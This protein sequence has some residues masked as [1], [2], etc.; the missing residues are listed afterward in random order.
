MKDGANQ[1]KLHYAVNAISPPARQ[2]AILQC[3]SPSVKRFEF[4]AS[5]IGKGHSISR[6]ANKC[7]GA[8]PLLWLL[9]YAGA[10]LQ[11][12]EGR[13]EEANYLTLSLPG[14]VETSLSVIPPE[15]PGNCSFAGVM[16]FLS[17]PGLAPT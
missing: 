16:L 7:K 15:V 13:A 12:P 2:S 5:K 9:L 17:S 6:K 8:G 1:N 11:F 3:H 4:S 10:A 14:T